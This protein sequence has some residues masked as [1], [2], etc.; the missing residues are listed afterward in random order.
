MILKE[1]K[2]RNFKSHKDTTIPFH[3][4]TTI[5]MGENGAGKST[6]LE[7]VHYALYKKAP[8]N[9]NNLIR[10]N[11]NSMSVELTFEEK[12]ATYKVVRTKSSSQST[13]RLYKTDNGRLRLWVEGNKEVDKEIASLLNIDSDLFLNSIYIKQGE[14]TDLISRKASER[15]RLITKLLRIDDLEKTWKTIPQ[16]TAEYER[17]ESELKGKLSNKTHYLNELRE[18][19]EELAGVKEKYTNLVE[20]G[21]TLLTEK[22]SVMGKRQELE[23]LKRKNDLLNDEL[24]HLDGLREYENDYEGQLEEVLKAEKQAQNILK[25]LKKE[26]ITGKKALL[27]SLN[28]DNVSLMSGVK[29]SREMLRDVS[30]LGD[31][32]PVCKSE[33]SDDK[34]KGLMT[35]YED[36][37]KQSEK[38]MSQNNEKI[39]QLNGKVNEL[40]KLNAR[41]IQFKGI[42]K[43]K[44]SIEDKLRKTKGKIRESEDKINTLQAEDY[45][46]EAYL[47]LSGLEDE[48]TIKLQENARETGIAKGKITKTTN[49][50]MKLEERID[51]MEYAK[52]EL[53]GIKDY[54]EFLN[55]FRE[56]CG[57][58][59][60]Q[61]ELRTMVKP[62]VQANT[63]RFFDEF[64]FQYS[65]LTLD[66]DFNITV[67]KED[68]ETL[69][70]D[71]VSGG[72]QISIALALRLGITQSISQGNIQCIILDEP[73]V[74]L[75]ALR[76]QE[77]SKLLRDTHIVPQLLIVTH[78]EALENSADNII[79][80]VKDNGTSEIV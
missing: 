12:G 62:I 22:E 16:I 35:L 64:D 1:L 70:M 8:T 75:D 59:G 79:T 49:I 24:R 3:K 71:M 36:K 61:L 76:V 73:T 68:D 40:D 2:L 38:R 19:K 66:D 33:I 46:K 6:I 18:Q 27:K 34:K 43:G 21:N 72:E 32:C 20:E 52:K 9:Q 48:L 4:G 13:S 23:L 63:N 51:E 53:K 15:K 41:F 44:E 37:I 77:L 5:I 45:D 80:V 47:R 11:Q 74:H 39:R 29:S 42:A 69:S 7:A 54:L 55:T 78:E 56:I 58:D 10:H 17:K 26:D 60:L 65:H 50:I 28:D 31:V 14:I 30:L 25:T 57:K 67:H